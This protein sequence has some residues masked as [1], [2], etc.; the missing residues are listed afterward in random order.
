MFGSTFPVYKAS[1]NDEVL[2]LLSASHKHTLLHRLLLHKPSQ[3]APSCISSTVLVS[4]EHCT[5]Q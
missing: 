4:T 3:L 1:G 2:A 5:F